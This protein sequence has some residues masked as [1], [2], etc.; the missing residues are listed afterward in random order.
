MKIILSMS[1]AMFEMILQE[2]C[3]KPTPL[4]VGWIAQYNRFWHEPDTIVNGYRGIF[5]SES[6]IEIPQSYMLSSIWER[7]CI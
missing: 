7:E 4:G 5:G 1:M 2:K 6:L 3:E